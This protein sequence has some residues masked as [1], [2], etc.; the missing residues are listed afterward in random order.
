MKTKAVVLLLAILVVTVAAVA[1]DGSG[2]ITLRDDAQVS[3]KQLKAGD[4]KV[5][6][7]GN[8]VTIL[9]NNKAVVT[10]TAKVTENDKAAP[11]DS[12]LYKGDGSS[13]S[14]A[15]IRFGGKKTVLVFD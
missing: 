11:Y 6:W 15:E 4:Y 10:T 1:A 5:K 2:S 12:I 8:D 9:Q 14:I 13:K 7:Q 3:G